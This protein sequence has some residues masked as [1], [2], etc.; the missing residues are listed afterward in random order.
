MKINT[1]FDP[2]QPMRSSR[3]PLAVAWQLASLFY[4]LSCKFA[5]D[6]KDV[7]QNVQSYRLLCTCKIQAL[8]NFADLW[9]EFL[10]SSTLGKK[11]CVNKSEDQKCV[12][13]SEDQKCMGTPARLNT[14][15]RD[16]MSRVRSLLGISKK[17]GRRK[18][19]IWGSYVL[20]LRLWRVRSSK[21]V[22]RLVGGSIQTDLKK[23]ESATIQPPISL[24]FQHEGPTKMHSV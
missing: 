8:Q 14:C 19:R 12:N 17:N 10:H 3:L 16:Q 6:N 21:P 23:K 9:C 15:L 22:P 11:G 7:L 13:K 1:I 5:L 4:E 20:N 2:A 24:Q 18:K